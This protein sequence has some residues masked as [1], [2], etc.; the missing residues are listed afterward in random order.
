M[1]TW[2][3]DILGWG[4]SDLGWFFSFSPSVLFLICILIILLGLLKRVSLRIPERL[5]SCDVV[6]KRNHLYEVLSFII[7]SY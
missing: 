2:A 6:S 4:F 3:V 5:P 1:E 7:F